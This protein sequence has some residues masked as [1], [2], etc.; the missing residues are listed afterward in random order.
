[1]KGK[2]SASDFQSLEERI[3]ALLLQV[4]PADVLKKLEELMLRIDKLTQRVNVL[5]EQDQT[6][7]ELDWLNEELKRL[8]N[9]ISG[10]QEDVAK[11]VDIEKFKE[12][13]NNLLAGL[14][15]GHSGPS[16]DPSELVNMRD[17]MMDQ[18]KALEKKFDKLARSLDLK[19]ILSQLGLKA[20][21]E[22]VTAE[23]GKHE[24]KLVVHEQAINDLARELEQLK[25]SLQKV[26]TMVQ[27]ASVTQNSLLSRRPMGTSTCLSCGRGEAKFAPML[28]AVMGS[29]GRVYRAD[30]NLMKVAS[31]PITDFEPMYDVGAEVFSMDTHEQAHVRA[32]VSLEE[33]RGNKLSV[34]MS[35]QQSRSQTMRAP[36]N[37]ILGTSRSERKVTTSTSS[38]MRPQSAKK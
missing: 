29:D 5:S 18:I 12:A 11:K 23:M 21:S 25:L 24:S 31:G 28:P 3:N 19:G 1:M 8:S 10:T 36:L 26:V 13:L 20:N 4:N 15:K 16:V 17:R 6:R 35:P 32:P 22:D 33:V 34:Q 37:V 30:G 27:D 2:C 9:R 38:R 14:P 7:K